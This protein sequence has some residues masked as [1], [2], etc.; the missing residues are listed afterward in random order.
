MTARPATE[1]V[2]ERIIVPLIFGGHGR[3]PEPTLTLLL[4]ALSSGRS[5]ATGRILAED[6]PDAAVV[7]A[8]DLRSF[9]PASSEATPDDVASAAAEWL[10]QALGYA[11]EQQRS[12]ILEGSFRS[13]ALVAGIARLFR[14]AG[15]RTRL[16]AVADRATETR[17]SAASLQLERMRAGLPGDSHGQAIDVAELVRAV[18]AKAAIDRVTILHRDGR[19]A[20]DSGS[21][22]S[23]SSDVVSAFEAAQREPLGTLRSALWLSELRHATQFATRARGVPQDAIAA[24][25]D[26]HGVALAEI[27]PELPI[28]V[29]SDARQIQEERLQASLTGLRELVSVEVRKSRTSE[30]QED[31]SRVVVAPAPDSSRPSL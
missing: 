10:Q 28:P 1:D 16:V 21:A 17:M 7:N 14:D 18:S 3:S 26:L 24:L 9:Y 27:V 25:V 13:P 19:V 29:S 4:G 12:L 15:F 5:R 11:R 30:V 31:V 20:Y 6:A 2:F 23:G 8:A 22:E